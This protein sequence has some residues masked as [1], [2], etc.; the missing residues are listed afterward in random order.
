MEEVEEGSDLSV[1]ENE[2]LQSTF[3]SAELGS[4]DGDDIFYDLDY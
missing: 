4:D 3:T 2:A 1:D